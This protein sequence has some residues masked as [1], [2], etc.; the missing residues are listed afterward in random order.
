MTGVAALRMYDLDEV[1]APAGELWSAIAAYLDD[2]PAELTWHGAPG[3]EWRAPDLVLGQTCGWPLI[4]DLGDD[5]NVVGAFHYDIGGRSGLPQYRSV[6]VAAEGRPLESFAGTVAAVNSSDSLSGWVS[7]GV[8]VAECAGPE[9]FFGGT[10]ETGSHRASVEA[11]KSGR[12]AIASV[13]AVSWALFERHLPSL[14]I[15]L[16]IVGCG[17]AV[18]TLPLITVDPDPEPLRAAVASAVA[19]PAN[20]D[21]CGQ[22]LINGFSPLDLS[23]YE[24][25]TAL[26]PVAAAVLGTC[27]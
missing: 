2:V 16:A 12:A 7:L 27:G 13:D 1:R 3:A 18:P 4:T 17:P 21:C 8:A 26:G 14:T 11:V 20:A 6:L 25:L 9:P 19:D 23:D 24:H 10:I 5:V 22:L 15:D